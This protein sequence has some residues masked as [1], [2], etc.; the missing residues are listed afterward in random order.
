MLACVCTTTR[1]HL[2]LLVQ[3]PSAPPSTPPWPQRG[4]RLAGAHPRP[5]ASRARVPLLLLLRPWGCDWATT[6]CAMHGRVVVVARVGQWG[7]GAR[8][9]SLCVAH[10]LAGAMGC[11]HSWQGSAE[12]CLPFCKFTIGAG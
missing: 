1:A 11:H 5:L 4:G 9:R 3:L 7:G 10:P 12:C 6:R 8:P 2:Q